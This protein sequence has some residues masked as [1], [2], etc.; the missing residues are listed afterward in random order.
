MIRG[1]A[2]A[3]GL[4]CAT[5]CAAPTPD[6]ADPAP[7]RIEAASATGATPWTHL[8]V[9]DAPGA[10]SFA[11]IADRTGRA[12]A[13]VF[14]D[15]IARLDLLRPAFVLS[16][17]DLIEGY[18]EDEDQLAAE[19]AELDALVAGLRA[20]FFYVAGN[21][22]Y[23]NAVMARDWVRRFGTSYYH[24]LYRG[25]LFLVLNSELFASVRDPSQPIRGAETLA[26]QMDFAGRVLREH[27]DARWTIVVL[28]Q[29]LWD[30]A[31]VHP[32]WLRLESLLGE[33]PYTVFAGH[34]HAYTRHVRHERSFVTLATTGGV[35]RL[36][37]IE[38]GEFDHLAL[39][40]MS[41]EGPVMANLML[42]GIHDEAVR[43]AA[44]RRAVDRL[45]RAVV[46]EP[47]RAEGERFAR[48][49]Q[50]I[51]VRNTVGAPLRVRLAAEAGP[52]LRVEPARLER[53][54]APEESA[55][56]E[57]E[58]TAEPPRPVEA[59]RPGVV[60]V[61]LETDG[62]R[63]PL[64]IESRGWI[65]PERV[66]RL[67]AAPPALR[68]DGRLDEWGALRF[69]LEDWP[70]LEGGRAEASLRFDVAVD[71]DD[72]VWAFAVRDP[73]PLADPE[74]P[75]ERQDGLRF[76]IDARPDPARSTN[77]SFYRALRE[78]DFEDLLL[79]TLS[80]RGAR[81][82]ETGFP[83]PL[84]DAVESAVSSTP[85]GYTAELRVPGALLDARAGGRWR[86]LRL[87]AVLQDFRPG[88]PEG[89]GHPWRVVRY[90][91]DGLPVEGSGTF[92]RPD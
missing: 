23:S 83:P 70:R 22:D 24:F 69:A 42:D 63:G 14:A 85:D 49:V 68:V 62:E 38:R 53:E 41:E 1:A 46:L 73:T 60:S 19:W 13:G 34:R 55:T 6:P 25:V 18:T 28:H 30:T 15:G 84:P 65:A 47:L 86:R 80:P 77:A 16:V 43:T 72:L 5:A 64:R 75:P 2:L 92:E 39:V 76:S 51:R 3:A 45:S 71:G 20:P 91:L 26:G 7:A 57:L 35:S 89:A 10:F 32:E 48:G 33:R 52:H 50:R 90:G 81:A 27:A 66:F 59:T 36:R 29:P 74:L 11:L 56:L 9:D 8:D 67:A 87:N 17:G 54:L 12:R 82:S 79:G 61:E 58:V 21:H 44:M 31:E 40:T 78:G 37:G 88:E 4:A